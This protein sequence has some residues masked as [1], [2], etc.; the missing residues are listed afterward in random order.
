MILLLLLPL[1]CL[2]AVMSLKISKEYS[3]VT[4]FFRC[5]V[6]GGYAMVHLSDGK[7]L[8]SYVIIIE[9][10][11]PMLIFFLKKKVAAIGPRRTKE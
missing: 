10:V 5:G 7:Y 8:L 9:I 2:L 4:D 11:N 3:S 6:N 1:G